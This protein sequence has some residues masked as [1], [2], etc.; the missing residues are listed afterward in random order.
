MK[1]FHTPEGA[2]SALVDD[3]FPSH[4]ATVTDREA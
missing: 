4:F 3:P 2:T 1:I